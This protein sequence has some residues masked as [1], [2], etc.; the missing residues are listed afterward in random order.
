MRKAAYGWTTVLFIGISL[1]VLLHGSDVAAYTKEALLLCGGTLLPSLFP[2]VFLTRFFTETG[3]AERA[4]QR[5]SPALSPLFGVRREL[6][7]TLLVGLFGGFPNGAYAAGS[8]YASGKCSRSE[9]ER[10]V[11]LADNAS[12][13]FLLTT[14]G[15]Y[16]LG[17]LKAGLILTAACVLTVLT[18]AQLLRFLYPIVEHKS[19]GTVGQS[20]PTAAV[21]CASLRA[22]CLSML[23]ICG[24]V[25]VFYALSGVLTAHL[26]E[27]RGA[28][29]FVRGA[30][31]MSGAVMEA[32]NFDFPQN[33]ILCAAYVGFSGLCVWFQITDICHEYG[34]SPR[35]FVF[36]RLSGG[37]L[38]P[39]FTAL[40]L[41]LLPVRAIGVFS[42]A[43]GTH[44]VQSFCR[45]NIVYALFFVLL[46]TAGSRACTLKKNVNGKSRFRRQK[47]SDGRAS[48]KNIFR[49]YEP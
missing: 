22:A 30:L 17:S 16:V 2:F 45:F 39:C 11:A 24:Y 38:C 41:L 33:Y 14:V 28:S 37:V 19:D 1:Y 32:A 42:S 12:F 21:F 6:C 5:F 35:P 29:A 25:T 18:N 47:L 34:L 43:E 3:T 27:F 8:A 20:R 13:A 10:I 40:L 46:L 15:V 36:T 48:H 7:G 4:G 26:S 49:N 31:E 23:Y 44:S 9:A